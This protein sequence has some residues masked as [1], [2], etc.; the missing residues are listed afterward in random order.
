MDQSDRDKEMKQMPPSRCHPTDA[1]QQM[2]KMGRLEGKPHACGAQRSHSSWVVQ[3][4]LGGGTG[5]YHSQPRGQ[6]LFNLSPSLPT[7]APSSTLPVFPFSTRNQKSRA[8][9]KIPHSP[10]VARIQRCS[11]DQINCLRANEAPTASLL[12]ISAARLVP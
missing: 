4:K 8:C 11:A 2:P 1:T 9:M 12:E 7:I 3:W 5:Q 10:H 6:L